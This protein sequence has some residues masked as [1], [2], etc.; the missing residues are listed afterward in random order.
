MDSST[1][2]LAGRTASSA[3][4]VTSPLVAMA[5]GMSSSAWVVSIDGVESVIRV[6]KNDGRRPVP[7]YAAELRLLELLAGRGVPVATGRVVVVDGFECSV[8]ARLPESPV[9][10]WSEA[11][12][13]DVAGALSVLHMTQSSLAVEDDV[14]AR[15]HLASIW[16][17]D[18][19]DLRDHAVA[20]WRPE[21]VDALEAHR[22]R[23]LDAAEGPR[24]VVHTDLHPQH[25]LQDDSKRLTGI[26]DFG[27]AF[28]G[29]AAWDIACLRYYQ[30]GAVAGAIVDRH[31]F[32][33]SLDEP[34]R[35]LGLPWGLYKLAKTPDRADVRE[36]V[37]AMFRA[38]GLC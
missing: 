15:F 21:L 37:D 31:V 7:R 8:A 22:K 30:G 9:A 3:G 26:L 33:R 24:T 11:F 29:T 20:A 5:D 25:L 16:P 18:S 13:D 14:S 23:I 38:A 2:S 17:F 10:E 35:L 1:R 6:P 4:E 32:G 36:R 27:D 28:A 12:I 34:A 19:T